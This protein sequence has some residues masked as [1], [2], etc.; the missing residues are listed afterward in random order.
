MKK[1]LLIGTLLYAMFIMSA[2]NNHIQKDGK[3]KNA[4]EQEIVYN[5]SIQSHFFGFSFGD[6]PQVVYKKLDSIRLYTTDRLVENGSIA[7]L[8]S[9]PQDDFKFGGFSWNYLYPYFCNGNLYCIRFLKPFKTKEGAVSMYNNLAS[10][11]SNKY[12][13]QT[14]QVSDSLYYGY[15][16]GRT[17][18]RQ[19][20]A[21]YCHRYESVGHE[22]WYGTEIVYGDNN[23]YEE[24]SE[25]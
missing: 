5:E 7:F 6:S 24:N 10:S 11:L 18:N 15:C 20:V 4:Q 21:L 12:Y 2:C 16:I 17:N 25:L 13:M 23:Y 1:T 3:P 14:M 8:P 19:Y 9:Y 22:M